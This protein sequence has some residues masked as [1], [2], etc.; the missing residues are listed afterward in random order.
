M[1]HNVD[2]LVDD[3]ISFFKPWGF[4]VKDIKVPVIFYHGTSDP[5]VPFN[6]AQWNSSQISPELV[7][8]HF[9]EGGGHASVIRDAEGILKELKAII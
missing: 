1:K 5:S 6:H 7:T 4:E 8:T 2:G 9:E 3:D